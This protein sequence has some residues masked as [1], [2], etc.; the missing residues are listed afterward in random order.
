MRQRDQRIRT[1]E[2]TLEASSRTPAMAQ[3]IIERAE[4]LVH[5]KLRN[6]RGSLGNDPLATREVYRTLFPDGLTFKPAECASRRVWHISG[7][8][9]IDGVK[10]RSDPNGTV[11]VGAGTQANRN[12]VLFLC[13]VKDLERGWSSGSMTRPR[14]KRGER[15]SPARCR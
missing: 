6:L 9:R 4:A 15:P 3:E 1:L 5:A 13:E 10:L 11:T 12:I 14:H 8:A 2:A 7:H